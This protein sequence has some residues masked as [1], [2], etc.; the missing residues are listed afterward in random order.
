MKEGKIMKKTAL[1]IALS[2]A[3]GI[4]SACGSGNATPSQ[5]T[6][7][8]TGTDN[9]KKYT[10]TMTHATADTTSLHKGALV[11][12]EYLESKSGG[13]I[14][15]NI[16]PNAQLGADRETIEGVQTGQI[17]M[18]ASSNAVQVNFVPDA[19]IFD[20]PFIYPNLETARKVL[21]DKN[22]IEKISASYAASGFHYLG[23]SDQG[24]RTLTANKPVN[25]PSDLAGVTLRTM[26][27]KYHM[28]AWKLMGSNPTPL[29]FNELY[30]ALQQG[31]VDAQEN[32]IEL[33]F[34]QK[35]YE[36]QKYIIGTN[37]ILQTIVW[38]MNEDFY[39][40]LPEDLRALVDSASEEATKV[41]NEYLDSS[42]DKLVKQMKDSGITFIDLTEEQLKA[43]SEKAMPVRDT[44][45]ANCSEAT[46]NAFMEAVNLATK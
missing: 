40:E 12:K 16:Y 1:V 13:R 34:S 35:F 4:L 41:A 27:N 29:A 42:V 3:I 38:I 25:S 28:E 8:N 39:Q 32:P 14:T 7:S 43:F 20:L 24:F 36:Q 2:L 6:A 31:T 22:F 46:Y 23:T 17:T 10:I 37:H 15:V 26:E 44:V 30:T 18:M 33:I 11:F 21:A 45:K 5:T 19:V 9:S